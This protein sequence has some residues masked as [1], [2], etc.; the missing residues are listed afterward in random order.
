MGEWK[1]MKSFDLENFDD[2]LNL[3]SLGISKTRI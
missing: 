1:Q 2:I 3:H